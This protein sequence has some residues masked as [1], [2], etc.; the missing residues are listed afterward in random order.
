M[1]APDGC[2]LWQQAHRRARDVP[3]R[4]PGERLG[5]LGRSGCQA[6]PQQLHDVHGVQRVVV[7]RG[8]IDGVDEP[9]QIIGEQ[10]GVQG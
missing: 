4:H 6:E 3:G 10:R 7:L 1:H 2:V 8:V 5:R 9:R